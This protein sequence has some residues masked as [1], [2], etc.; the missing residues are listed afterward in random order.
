[1]NIDINSAHQ[2]MGLAHAMNYLLHFFLFEFSQYSRTS[3]PNVHQI[4][5]FSVL[6]ELMSIGEEE[7]R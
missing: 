1:M 2:E 3:E 4:K 6:L 7:P 5:K